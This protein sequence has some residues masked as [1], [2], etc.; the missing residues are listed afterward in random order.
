MC[1]EKKYKRD[2]SMID[3]E[4]EGRPKKID[5]HLERRVIRKKK[6]PSKVRP[7]LLIM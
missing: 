3:E 2:P 7:K 4:R 6:T 5:E 1:F